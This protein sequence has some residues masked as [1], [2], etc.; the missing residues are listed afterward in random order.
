LA[1]SGSA[2]RRL[3]YRQPNGAFARV[4]PPALVQSHSRLELSRFLFQAAQRK[5]GEAQG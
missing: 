5:T 3:L 2:D 4:V 1:G